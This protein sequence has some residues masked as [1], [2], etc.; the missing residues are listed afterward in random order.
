M[1]AA[2]T[3]ATSQRPSPA[4]GRSR[5]RIRSLAV[6]G[7][8]VAALAVWALAELLGVDLQVQGRQGQLE[9]VGP[10]AVALSSVLAGLAGWAA[11]AVLERFTGH[12]RTAWTLLAG[13][14][15]AL[16]MVGPLTGGVTAGAKAALALMHLAVAVVLVPALRRSSPTR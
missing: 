3:S 4:A 1:T 7:A 6:L 14:V 13:V 16:S 15:L 8:A 10:A 2:A 12:A 9:A 11:L 5:T